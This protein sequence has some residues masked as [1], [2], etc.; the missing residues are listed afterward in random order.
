MKPIKIGIVGVGTIGQLDDFDGGAWR[1]AIVR[2]V[3][4]GESGD[5]HCANVAIAFTFSRCWALGR[6]AAR[7]DCHWCVRCFKVLHDG[8]SQI[9]PAFTR[10][11]QAIVAEVTACIA[12]W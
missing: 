1:V 12:N 7:D 9:A 10:G 5:D 6:I 11:K 3:A 4:D 2:R 8:R